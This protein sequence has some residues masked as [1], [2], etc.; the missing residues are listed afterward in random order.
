MHTYSCKVRLGGSVINEVPKVGVTVPEMVLLQHVHGA[1]SIS[2]VA[3]SKAV[4][5]TEDEER[6]RLRQVYGTSVK[7]KQR[8][9]QILGMDHQPLPDR[10]PGIQVPEPPESPK[11][12]GRGRQVDDVMA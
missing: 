6:D 8:V 7:S 5:R 12:G 10:V 9:E 4:E 1:D 3:Y 11:K 2:N